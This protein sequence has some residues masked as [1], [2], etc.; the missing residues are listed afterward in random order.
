MK[1]TLV[2]LVTEMN[3]MCLGNYVCITCHIPLQNMSLEWKGS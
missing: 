3:I 2:L 1:P